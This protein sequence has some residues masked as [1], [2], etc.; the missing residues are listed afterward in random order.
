MNEKCVRCD[1][2]GAVTVAR[3]GGNVLAACCERCAW[4]KEFS[5]PADCEKWFFEQPRRGELFAVGDESLVS[6]A[7]EVF[8][9]LAARGLSV[10]CT[11]VGEEARS[12]R[13]VHIP[14][15]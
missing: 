11:I 9:E 7:C 5:R 3:V 1:C 6:L 8:E 15:E 13:V 4:E 10:A 12:V 2:G 14:P